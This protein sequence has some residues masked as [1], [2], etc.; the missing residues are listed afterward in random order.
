M[1]K[2]RKM[3]ARLILAIVSTLLEEAA[4]VAIVLWALPEVDIEIPLPFLVVI[5]A[6]WLAY[7]VFTFRMGTRALKRKQIPG[8][9]HMIGSKG[10]IVAALAPEGMV[11]IKGELWV[12]KSASGEMVSGGEVV[13]VGQDGLK[14]VVSEISP[15][16]DGEA[17]E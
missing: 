6:A 13:V 3:T 8:L 1:R 11:R 10:E 9:P 15:V 7:S 14:L 12:A 4:I 16:S 2:R 5:M 17:T